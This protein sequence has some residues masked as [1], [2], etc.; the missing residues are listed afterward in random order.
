MVNLNGI[1]DLEPEE[2]CGIRKLEA[3]VP[4]DV[5]LTLMKHGIIPDPTVRDHFLQC[6]WVGEHTWIY[7]RTFSGSFPELPSR[8]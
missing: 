7:S 6:R 5:L 1:W 3:D 2:E 4:G 8:R